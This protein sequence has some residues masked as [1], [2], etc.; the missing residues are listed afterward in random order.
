MRIEDMPV[1][2]SKFVVNLSGSLVLVLAGA[3]DLCAEELFYRYEDARGLTVIDD[4]VPPEFARKGYTVL[5]KHGRVVEVVPR[6]LTAREMKNGNSPAVRKQMQAEMRT[7]QQRYDEVLLGRYSSAT[8]IEAAMWRKV[9][10]IKVRI[11]S[12][13]GSIARLSSQ[14]EEKQREAADLERAG[15][16]VPEG[17]PR[18]IAELRAE[19]AKAEQDIQLQEKDRKTTEARFKY[20]KKRFLELRPPPARPAE[21]APAPTAAS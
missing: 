21:P 18:S 8:D 16:T 9:N 3:G 12:L 6:E 20:D 5:N 15:E 14:V 10:E 11:N 2:L 13:K 4:R 17:L 1:Q 7:R 19:I